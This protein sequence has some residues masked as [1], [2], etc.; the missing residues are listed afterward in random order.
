MKKYIEKIQPV[1]AVLAL[2]M[3]IALIYSF[4]A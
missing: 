1:D 3:I 2:P 4:Y